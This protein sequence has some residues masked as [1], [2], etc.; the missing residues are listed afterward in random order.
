M[1]KNNHTDPLHRARRLRAAGC[2][3]HIPDD[4][5]DPRHIPSDDLRVYQTGGVI[6][7][8]A[9]DWGGGTA[10]KIYLVITSE[11]SGLAVSHFELMLPWT[12]E[13]SRVQWLEDPVTIDGPSRCYRFSGNEFLEFERSLVINHRLDVTRPF[14]AGES[15]RGFLLGFGYDP[16]PEE[17]PHGKM[18]PAFLVLY[19]QFTGDYRAPVELWADR[20]RKKRP[21]KPLGVPRKGGLLDKRD[22]IV[23]D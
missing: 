9:F 16:I 14:S 12:Q 5:D 1:K 13:G 18:I 23:R 8:T 15:A 19:D 17:F 20:M 11:I 3:I 7:S 22:T 6:E 2:Q 21:G 10:Y 4:D